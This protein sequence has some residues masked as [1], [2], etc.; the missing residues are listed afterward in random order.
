MIYS[1][2]PLNGNLFFCPDLVKLIN[3]VNLLL[4]ILL[5]LHAFNLKMLTWL[6]I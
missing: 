4:K 3:F 2:V 5:P 1:K 6:T